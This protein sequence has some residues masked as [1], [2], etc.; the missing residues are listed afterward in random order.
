[1]LERVQSHCTHKENKRTTT[2]PAPSHITHQIIKSSNHRRNKRRRQWRRRQ[3]KA[4]QGTRR[5][6]LE[7]CDAVCCGV[8]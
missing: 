5:D 1:M 7:R 6:G 8:G 3:G 4:R 2:A